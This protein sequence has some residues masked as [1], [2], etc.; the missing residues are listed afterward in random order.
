MGCLTF[1][2]FHKRHAFLRAEQSQPV[3]I[4]LLS[5]S[6]ILARSLLVI[7]AL[8]AMLPLQDHPPD[9]R[10]WKAQDRTQSRAISLLRSCASKQRGAYFTVGLLTGGDSFLDVAGGRSE[11]RDEDHLF[12]DEPKRHDESVFCGD[13]VMLESVLAANHPS[14][15]RDVTSATEALAKLLCDLDSLRSC[16]TNGSSSVFEI[17]R[18]ERRSTTSGVS[19]SRRVE[20]LNRTSSHGDGDLGRPMTSRK[21]LVASSSIAPPPDI[22]KSAWIDYDVTL[23]AEI[24]K[25]RQF[26]RSSASIA[27]P[28]VPRRSIRTLSDSRSSARRYRRQFLDQQIVHPIKSPIS[29]K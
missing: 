4:S 29:Q 26:L 19:V 3:S 8:A 23:A 20:G 24:H 16:C 9:H 5:A 7:L 13:T 15:H 22:R 10:P 25:E 2:A 11:S 6:I 14:K 28:D 12:P 1:S 27:P 21:M 18:I 17:R